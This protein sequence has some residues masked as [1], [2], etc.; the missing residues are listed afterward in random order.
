MLDSLTTNLDFVCRR[1]LDFLVVEHA[2]GKPPNAIG[3]RFVAS[4]WQCRLRARTIVIFM[5][6]KQKH[7]FTSGPFALSRVGSATNRTPRQINRNFIFNLIRRWQPISRA[8]LARHSGLQRSTVS[9]IIEDLVREGW[10]FEGATGSLPRGR[11][12]VLI[13]LYDRR[14]VVALDVHPSRTA[15]AIT[16]LSGKIVARKV[17]VPPKDPMRTLNAICTEICMLIA[18]HKEKSFMGVGICLPG[19]TDPDSLSIFAPRLDWPVAKL[20]ARV[21]RATRLPVEMDNV[22]NACALAEVWFGDSDAND[23]LVIVNVSEGISIGIFV[24]GRILRGCRGMAGEF[25]HVQL[26]AEDGILCACGNRGCWETLASNTAALRYHRELA[27]KNAAASFDLLIKAALNGQ[28]TAV[29]AITRSAVQLGGGIRILLSGLAPRE[30][31]IVGELAAAW[32][33]LAPIVE[34]EITRD[35]LIKIP[36]LRCTSD[37]NDS[38]LRAAAAL[39]LSEWS[40]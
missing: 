27:G 40:V 30:I 3:A 14:G 16:D 32:S 5:T 11:R 31:V 20:K 38:R 37:G 26:Q 15:I 1:E 22:A 23:G 17:I 34:K 4:D 24:N 33:L 6:D 28:P 21:A 2:S 12:P 13:Q 18:K 10:L 9:L 19:R 29:Q 35:C 39:V 8:D 36:K 7:S 25:G